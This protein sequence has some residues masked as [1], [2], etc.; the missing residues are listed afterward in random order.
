MMIRQLVHISQWNNDPKPIP[1]RISSQLV[2]WAIGISII[3]FVAGLTAGSAA[4]SPA[5][6]SQADA[7]P[8]S[9][10]ATLTPHDLNQSLMAG[11]SAAKQGK[12]NQAIAI[13]TPL[14]EDGVAAAQFGLGLIYRRG[15]GESRQDHQ[16]H[17]FDL[18]QKAGLQGH[19]RA[20]FQ[21]GVG[22][23][24]GLGTEQDIEKA[25]F[26]YHLAAMSHNVGAQV[27]LAILNARG[28]SENDKEPRDLTKAY[29]WA[30]IAQQQIKRT[31]ATPAVTA[32]IHK[33][34]TL[35]TPKV[36]FA[37]RQQ[38]HKAVWKLLGQPI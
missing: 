15:H 11:A 7:A 14:A 28:T 13:W 8:T 22:H 20:L 2:V 5:I 38:A 30:L 19:V 16:E 21:L 25:L 32:R 36:N 17:A 6:H 12:F 33:L 27:N 37:Q 10:S 24:R 23:E 9:E 18:F 29:Q 31:P 26:F 34:V 3:S 4:A 1:E 35:L